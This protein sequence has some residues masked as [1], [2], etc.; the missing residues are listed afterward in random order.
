[1][2]RE[3]IFS[4]ASLG[5]YDGFNNAAMDHFRDDNS[6]FREV[7]Q[8]SI[9]N[10]DTKI[11]RPVL[12][13]FEKKTFPAEDLGINQQYSEILKSSEKW[14]QNA[15]KDDIKMFYKSAKAIARKKTVDALVVSDY[16]TTG[17]HRHP[18][19]PKSNF[20]RLILNPGASKESGVGGGS[21]G[22][23]QHAA[24]A[25]SQ[26]RTV[27]F[28][29]YVE[30][31]IKDTDSNRLFIGR[32]ILNSWKDS[33]LAVKRGIGFFCNHKPSE[34]IPFYDTEVPKSVSSLR[35]KTG[36]D[37]IITEPHLGTRWQYQ[38]M[39]QIV[40]HFFAAIDENRLKIE[41][42]YSNRDIRVIQKSTIDECVTS[43]NNKQVKK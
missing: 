40:R 23:G 43:T 34:V 19:D 24:Y 32:T 3:W 20:Y 37:I 9:D 8:N 41:L 2:K 27:C 15:D 17:L 39:A 6:I 18:T 16:H 28:H 12:I 14:T 11:K 21:H 36:T 30:K 26:L 42:V 38:A 10:K 5:P 31:G 35:D 1:M 7:I 33:E 13:K 4:D 29:S 25:R 22:H